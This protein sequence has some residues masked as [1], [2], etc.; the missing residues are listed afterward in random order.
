MIET[1]FPQ[2]KYLVYYGELISVF[3]W[4]VVKGHFQIIV[5]STF[6]STARTLLCGPVCFCYVSCNLET[7]MCVI[8]WISALIIFGTICVLVRKTSFSNRSCSPT[9]LLVYLLYG[10]SFNFIDQYNYIDNELWKLFWS[11]C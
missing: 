9:T 2:S 3:S 11:T 8:D 5:F 10:Y 7:E 4:R 6:T 1:I